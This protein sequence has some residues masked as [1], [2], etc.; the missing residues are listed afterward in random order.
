MQGEIEKKLMDMCI[1]VAKGMEYLASK[2]VIHRDLAARNC[3]YVC[4]CK[5][6]AEYVCIANKAMLKHKGQT[7]LPIHS[8]LFPPATPSPPTLSV[9]SSSEV[10]WKSYKL[11][12]L[13]VKMQD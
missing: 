9:L 12:I 2:R 1:Q 10:K 4:M 3:M 11:V 5:R 8:S 7:I 13:D 6:P